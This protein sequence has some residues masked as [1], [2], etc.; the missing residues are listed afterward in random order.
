MLL[1]NTRACAAG[2]PHLVKLSVSDEECSQA[3][4]MLW[5]LTHQSIRIQLLAIVDTL[6]QLCQKLIK[7]GYI[8]R[9]IFG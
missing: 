6:K 7:L 4:C 9:G 1:R 5:I 8:H 3:G 2:L